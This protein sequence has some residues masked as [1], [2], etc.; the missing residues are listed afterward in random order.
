MGLI[1]T[2]SRLFAVSLLA[3]LVGGCASSGL[4][5]T[6]AAQCDAFRPITYSSKKDTPET[7]K[8][9]RTHN[10]AYKNLGCLKK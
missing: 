3:S 4:A 5:T 8:Q 2:R 6:R 9:V 10:L 1:E 7:V